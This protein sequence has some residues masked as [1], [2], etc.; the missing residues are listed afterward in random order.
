MGLFR[1]AGS[2][3]PLIICCP[4]STTMDHE[5]ELGIDGQ[6]RIIRMARK[7]EEDGWR[8]ESGCVCNYQ[9][10][11]IH[12]K[13][14]PLSRRIRRAVDSCLVTAGGRRQ[15]KRSGAVGVLRVSAGADSCGTNPDPFEFPPTGQSQGSQGHRPG[16]QGHRLGSSYPANTEPRRGA[17][18]ATGA[19]G[20][21]RRNPWQD[22]ELHPAP[23]GRTNYST[24]PR[25]RALP[26]PARRV[27]LTTPRRH[28]GSAAVT[29]PLWHRRHNRHRPTVAAGLARK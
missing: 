22:R 23:E 2:H 28:C 21:R 24:T 3:L 14:R 25:P 4:R 11:T 18:M 17:R 5:E 1:R 9:P 7:N 29:T 27:R 26:N 15:S 16:F 13:L 10:A 6:P 19:G 20:H 12:Y 8:S